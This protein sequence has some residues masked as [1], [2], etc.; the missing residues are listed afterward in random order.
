MTEDYKKTLLDYITNMTPGQ[1]TSAEIFKEEI[2]VARS[3]WADF[4][5]PRWADFS[6]EG[7]IK[8]KT[9]DKVIFYGGYVVFGETAINDSRGII[10]VTDSYLKPIQT[11]YTFS[12]GTLLRPIQ[13]MFQEEDG[14]F[15]AIDST[16]MYSVNANYDTRRA[17]MTNPK[18][19]IM[20]NDISQKKDDKYE[21]NLRRSY[22]LTG[23]YT[24][25]ICKNIFKNPSSSHYAFTGLKIVIIN[26]NIPSPSAIKIISL[27]I[28]VGSPNEWWTY[29]SDDR[30]IYGGG[31]VYF[32]S[33]DDANWKFLITRNKT[34]ENKILV[35]SG[36]N[37][38]TSSLVTL[39][40]ES[41][42]V[43]IDSFSF[44]NQVAFI[45][46]N[47]A[48][49]VM[50]NQNWGISGTPSPKYIGLYE[51]DLSNNTIREVYL[52]YLGD[53]DFSY[54]DI[55]CLQVVNGELYIQY[56][57]NV[58]I[59]NETAN[60]YVQR[61]KGTWAPILVKEN[62]KF[63]A[64]QRSFYVSQTFNILKL[65]IIPI[66]LRR[67]TWYMEQITEIYNLLNYNGED[68]ENY[69]SLIAKYGN[70]YSDNKII[71][72]RNLHNLSITNN[73]TVASI[74]VPN[75]YLNDITFDIKELVGETNTTLISD[76]NPVSKN[77]YEVL[78]F[79]YINTLNVKDN[80]NEIQLDTSKYVNSNINIGTKTNHDN[81]KCTKLEIVYQDSTN[82][83]FPIGWVST[84][85]THKYTE[86]TIYVDKPISRLE[87]IS[88][89][90][91]TTYITI[92]QELEV[93]KYYTFKQYLKVE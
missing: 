88:N 4:V 89:D 62:A 49:Y 8:S 48:Y 54:L 73:Y 28:N 58:D 66:N 53:Y 87:L 60:Y 45:N 9:S 52:K 39:Q 30:Y 19:V 14:Q 11:I 93:G 36:K 85:S 72:S 20:L 37:A 68:Y 41:F 15:I 42:E 12:S 34:N 75:T 5:P 18:R 86:F 67:A 71:F 10:I 57:D 13:Q 38:T 74:E 70:I 3:E 2:E 43:Y 92:E 1:S 23:Q 6:I 29:D 35:W 64:A 83:I 59:V 76:S 90:Q 81:T 26:D 33:N 17:L 46:E 65:N 31:Y 44:K 21:V 84:D 77:I 22:N 63:A 80:E 50:N 82:K 56:C 78:Y 47:K 27:K 16:I 40:Q 51:A 61:Y 24:N 79:N 91:T 25:F 7:I 55:M 69:N 32:D